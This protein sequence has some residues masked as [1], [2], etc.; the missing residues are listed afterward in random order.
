LTS[1]FRWIDAFR[2]AILGSP[3]ENERMVEMTDHPRAWNV[4]T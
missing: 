3:E 2:M 1:A 4:V